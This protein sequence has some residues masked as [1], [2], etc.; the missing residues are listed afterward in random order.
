MGDLSTDAHRDGTRYS[1][2]L[3]DRRTIDWDR[4]KKCDQQIGHALTY[5][6]PADKEVPDGTQLLGCDWCGQVTTAELKKG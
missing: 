1:I 2:E 3:I 6:G 4:L 5:I